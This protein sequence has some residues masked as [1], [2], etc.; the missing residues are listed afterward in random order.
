MEQHSQI[1]SI[2]QRICGK[3]WERSWPLKLDSIEGEL[4]KDH[5]PIYSRWSRKYSDVQCWLDMA[6][7]EQ[8][9]LVKKRI[10]YS[11]D[12]AMGRRK[13]GTRKDRLAS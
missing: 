5:V 11:L 3:D 9:D 12:N 13:G 1:L 2:V 8:L 7:P 4:D 6:L 10:Q